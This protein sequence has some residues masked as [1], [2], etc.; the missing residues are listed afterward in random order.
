MNPDFNTIIAAHIQAVLGRPVTWG[1]DDCAPFVAA[2]VQD[3]T[4]VDLLGNAW[5]GLW[6]SPADVDRLTPL[7]LG[8]TVSRRMRDCG[9][10]RIAPRRAVA[11]SVCLL[12]AGPEHIVGL[13]LP[14]GRALARGSK[15]VQFWPINA[16]VAAWERP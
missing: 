8:V 7:G 5:R 14:D 1:L 12:R 6:S 10:Q 9:W 15:G 11:G 16:A 13:V 2:I 4:G 3:L